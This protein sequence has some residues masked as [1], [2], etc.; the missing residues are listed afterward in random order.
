MQNLKCR[1]LGIPPAGLILSGPKRRRCVPCTLCAR[2]VPRSA[3]ET[4]AS[5]LDRNGRTICR[6]FNRARHPFPSLASPPLALD[7]SWSFIDEMT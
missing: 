1:Q 6:Q 7:R 5:Q 2:R 4:T 3:R